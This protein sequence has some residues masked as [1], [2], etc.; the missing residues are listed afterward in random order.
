MPEPL[1]GAGPTLL[2][3]IRLEA[4]R[5]GGGNAYGY[6]IVRSL[7]PDGA[8][9]TGKRH[10]NRPEANFAADVCTLG[11]SLAVVFFLVAP[12]GVLGVALALLSGTCAGASLR[13]LTL[14]RCAREMNRVAAGRIA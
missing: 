8:V 7:R 12:L 10:I 4:G 2:R 6:D 14:I 11:V 3:A 1:P 13:C 9:D 5:S